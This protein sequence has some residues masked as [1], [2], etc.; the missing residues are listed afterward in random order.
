MSLERDDVAAIDTESKEGR[1]SDAHGHSSPP[2][3][4][5]ANSETT[6]VK[7]E[8][9][10]ASDREKSNPADQR[11]EIGGET[12]QQTSSNVA[13]DDKGD[14]NDALTEPRPLCI[15]SDGEMPKG[16]DSEPNEE[17]RHRRKNHRVQRLL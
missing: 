3:K 5:I 14:G 7:T 13:S 11:S 9:D 17:G 8:L 10:N 16:E 1:S 6:S 12:Q 15:D 4:L 2:D